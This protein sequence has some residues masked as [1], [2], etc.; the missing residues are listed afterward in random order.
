ML[1]AMA[2][3]D[4]I[5]DAAERFVQTRGFNGF[6]Y[7]DIASELDVTKASLHYHFA[8][9]GD[10]GRALIV[11]YR[12]VF[13]RLLS[14]IDDET[15]RATEKLARYVALY[16]AVL[17]DDRMCLCGMVAA[18]Y[19][20]LPKAMQEEIRRFFSVNEEWLTSVIA[21]GVRAGDLDL[22]GGA[23]LDAA[24]LLIGALEGAMLVART[25]KS[26]DR[27]DAAAR[28]LLEDLAPA[29]RRRRAS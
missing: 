5:L 21:G 2:T 16:R 11:R 12:E 8:T 9:K 22:R 14:E 23:A 20:T 24:R 10:L 19:A 29:K 7:A 17:S 26:V 15:K 18:E 3:A 1:D 25:Y 4:R 6:S 28:R 13:V 27:F